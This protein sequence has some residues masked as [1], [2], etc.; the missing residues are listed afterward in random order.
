MFIFVFL[1]SFAL[2]FA[3]V[4]SLVLGIIN[5][6]DDHVFKGIL[7]IIFGLVL[8]VYLVYCIFTGIPLLGLTAELAGG[9]VH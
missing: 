7:D 9:S 8:L 3:T 4:N 1:V 6:L 2:G 5:V